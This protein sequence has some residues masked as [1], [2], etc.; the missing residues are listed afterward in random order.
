MTKS[1]A[2]CHP[3]KP[4]AARGFCKNCYA[5]W[6]YLNNPSYRSKA[7]AMAKLRYRK[8]PEKNK[9]RSLINDRM[10][11][12]G[13]SKEVFDGMVLS[14]ENRCKICGI[15]FPSGR[16]PCVDHDHRTGRVRG[17]LCISCNRSLGVLENRKFV[18]AASNYLKNS[19]NV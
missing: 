8:N 17:V 11:R 5:S 12:Y 1:P 13:L 10:R 15:D 7:I 3:E 18:E 14:Q 4:L 16:S 19:E 6:I 9:A 2:S